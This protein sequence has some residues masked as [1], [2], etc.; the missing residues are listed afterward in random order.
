MPEFLTERQVIELRLAHKTT[1][2][3]KAADKIKAI[4]CLHNGYSYEQIAQVLMIDEVTTRR[5]VQKYQEKGIGGLLECRYTGGIG[6]LTLTQEAGLKNYLTY[7]TPQTARAVVAHLK[8]RYCVDYTV[9]GVT[10]LLH[11]LGFVYKK[12]KVMPGNVDLTKQ[13]A[14]IEQY[15]DLKNNLQPNDRIY[16]AD[17]T[18]PQ[19]NTMRAYGWILKGKAHDKY[20]KTNTG[21]KRLNLNGALNLQDKT[22]VVL[23]EQTINAQATIHLLTTIKQKQRTG[24]VYVILD[25]ASY[26][27]SKVVRAWLKKH[28]RFKT[29]FLPPYSPNLNIIER[30][31]LFFHKKVTY[32]RYFESFEEFKKTSLNFFK[33]L[34]YYQQELSSLLTDSFQTLPA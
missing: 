34:K 1:R 16:F 17:A 31:W 14:F 18:H 22:A 8:E 30:L 3:K 20:I 9:V 2:D 19:H 12:P 21:R 13:A 24:N 6:K 11:R 28:R 4:M 15:Q 5:Y 7:Q 23:E 10:K 29:V 32:N 33:D 26:H 27:H 25:N